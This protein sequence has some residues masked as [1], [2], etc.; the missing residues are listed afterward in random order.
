MDND[1]IEDLKKTFGLKR[2]AIR[3]TIGQYKG[4]SIYRDNIL[5]LPKSDSSKDWLGIDLRRIS[6]LG[7][8]LST[9]QIIGII[10]YF[11]KR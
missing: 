6:S 2:Q 1:N 4:L 5:V 10:L 3:N 11:I 8:R 7:K 9:S